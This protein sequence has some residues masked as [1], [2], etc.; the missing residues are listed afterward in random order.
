MLTDQRVICLFVHLILV[1]V[2]V[3]HPAFVRAELLFLPAWVLLDRLTALLAN[4]YTFR[5]WMAAQMGLHRIRRKI[6]DVCNAF[7][8]VTFERKVLDLVLNV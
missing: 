5:R 7:V 8:S 2:P 3:C 4:G 6:Q 1:A